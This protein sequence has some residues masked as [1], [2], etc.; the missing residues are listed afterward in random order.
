MRVS[1][2]TKSYA[3]TE[4]GIEWLT[5]EQYNI[6]KGPDVGDFWDDEDSE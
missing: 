4:N 2:L 5:P 6:L 3:I 1:L